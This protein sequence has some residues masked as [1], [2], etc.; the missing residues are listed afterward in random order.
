MAKE[1]STAGI[2][3]RHVISRV[4]F[5]HIDKCRKITLDCIAYTTRLSAFGRFYRDCG[6]TQG[7]TREQQSSTQLQKRKSANVPFHRLPCILAIIT[8]IHLVRVLRRRTSEVARSPIRGTCHSVRKSGN[9]YGMHRTSTV[10][11]P[12]VDISTFSSLRHRPSTTDISGV[13]TLE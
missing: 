13:P 2:V 12:D 9:K 3:K 7:A 6:D 4:R 8:P 11:H 1:S 5:F 10:I